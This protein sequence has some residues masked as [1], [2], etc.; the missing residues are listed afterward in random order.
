MR[1]D[2][3]RAASEPILAIFVRNVADQCQFYTI[4]G[5]WVNREPTGARW[6]V[7]RF[8]D[9]DDLNK[10]LPYL[11]AEEVAVEKMNRLHPVDVHAPR[12][13]GAKVIEQMSLFHQAADAVFRTHAERINRLYDI[14]APSV[15]FTDQRYMSLKDITM[16]V[17]MKEDRSEPTQPM[18]WAIH[19]AIAQCQ[20]ITWDRMNYRQNPTYAIYPRQGLS[21][22]HQVREWVREYQEGITQET[23]NQPMFSDDSTLIASTRSLNPIATFVRKARSAL[24]HSRRTRSLSKS[25][26]IGPSSTRLDIE[27]NSGDPYREI[28][29]QKFDQNDK[30]IIH[31]LDVW[32][33]SS[34]VNAY[35][36]LASLGPMILRA[37]GMYEGFELN[38]SRGFTLLQELGVVT[39]WENKTVYKLKGLKLP[40][41][42]GG[43]GE[44]SLKFLEARTENQYFEPKDSME[45]LRRDWGDMLVF[46]IDSAETMERDDGISLEP[47]DND[48]SAHWVHVHVA[49]PS[50]FITPDSAMAKYAAL[51]AESVYF[52]ERKYPMLDPGLT[53]DRLGLANDRPCITFSAKISADGDML[54]K[55]ITPGIVRN[56]HYLTPQV[57]GQGLGLT[58]TVEES[59]TLSILTVGGRMPTQHVEDL[60]L[61]SSALTDPGHIKALRKLLELGEAARHKRARAGA[62]D[63][64]SSARISSSYP[65]VYAAKCADKYSMIENK[66]VRQFEGD[67]VITLQRTTES[68]GLVAK[69]V[70]DLMIIAGDVGASWCSE[71]NIPIP[72]RGIIRN[73]EPASSPEAFKREVLGPKIAKYGHA[74]QADLRRY[75]RLVGQAQ[76]SD[77]PLPHLTLGLPAYCK[78]TSPLRRY[79]D[80]Y[81]HWQIEAAI[82]HEAATGTSLVGSTDNSYLP[83]SRAQVEE[84][85]AGTLHRERTISLAKNSSTRHWIC[86]ALFRAFYFKEAT[87]PE[88]FEVRTVDGWVG[89]G[90]CPGWS[91]LLNVKVKLMQCAAV[92]S[93][94]GWRVGDVWEARLDAVDPYYMAIQMEPVRLLER[95]GE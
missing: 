8:V 50:A 3:F 54:E 37:I 1:T 41:H 76:A 61:N 28:N 55:K 36:N 11:P 59:E 7:S 19:R 29:L 14:I 79:V 30:L 32:A 13:A 74:E 5:E 40:G 49:N 93:E 91:S 43:L 52:P 57:V 62:P 22:I 87:L 23:T 68:Y 45:A 58:K 63:F 33:N 86:Q 20:N 34:Y 42:D 46:C 16:K 69:M 25:G 53:K 77:R 70:S 2:G 38:Q 10:I 78:T 73:P 6:A 24:R 35:T 9:P 83:F 90:L 66:H 84:F 17:L 88:T 51:L 21:Y 75:M 48:P 89:H 27:Q 71:R 81:A 92:T 39:P 31:Y 56:V 18:M 72:Y 94:G 60:D 67:P 64:Y 4:R 15:G 85:A 80:L 44:V 26:F 47:D 65:I 82:R 95:E 12:D